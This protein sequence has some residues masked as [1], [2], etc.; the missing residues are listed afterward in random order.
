MRAQLAACRMAEHGPHPC[1]LPPLACPCPRR[2]CSRAARLPEAV[3]DVPQRSRGEAGPDQPHKA[4]PHPSQARARG[5]VHSA[6]HSP[7]KLWRAALS[8]R[9]GSWQLSALLPASPHQGPHRVF[10]HRKWSLGCGIRA[11]WRPCH[12]TGSRTVIELRLATAACRPGPPL[13]RAAEPERHAGQA[14][15]LPE[16]RGARGGH[17]GGWV[18]ERLTPGPGTS[19]CS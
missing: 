5:G 18:S 4:V 2:H 8:W 10:W 11:A 3:W 1:P 15:L 12:N 17:A 13:L 7:G 16:R 19:G 9:K 14:Q 6:L